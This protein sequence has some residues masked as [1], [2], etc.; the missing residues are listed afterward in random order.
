[1]IA[2]ILPTTTPYPSQ[3]A[4]IDE[5]RAAAATWFA[6]RNL[7]LHPTYAH[8]LAQGVH[9]RENLILHEVRAYIE[10]EIADADKKVARRRPFALNGAINNGA[11]S[12]AMAFNLVGPL[13]TRGDLQP[14]REVLEAAGVSWPRQALAAF[15]VESRVVFNEQGAQPT[16]VDLVVSGGPAD[17]GPI[18]IEVKLIEGGFGGCG[19]LAENKCDTAGANPLADLSQ[20][21]LHRQGALY[22]KRLAEHGLTSDE[23]RTA[24]TCM[25]AA[26]YQFLREVLFALYHGGH[27][28]LLHDARSPIFDGAPRSVLPQLRAK[29]PTHL[30]RRVTAITVQQVVAAIRASGRHD[31]WIGEFERKHGL[32]H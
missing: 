5:V 7:P 8:I 2:T 13:I 4:L 26:D 17:N 12:Q 20:C 3:K 14:L 16:S 9:W 10:A 22:W 28:V 21:Y 31:D 15:E 11:S 19:T 32:A 18:M 25:M 6:S 24:A 30:R 29:L 1:M 23:A 27:F